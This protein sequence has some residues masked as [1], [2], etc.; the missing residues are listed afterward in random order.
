MAS[1]NKEG[2]IYFWGKAKEYIDDKVDSSFDLSDRM[3]KGVDNQG[4]EVTGAVMEGLI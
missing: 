1:L 4:N 2:L 3:A